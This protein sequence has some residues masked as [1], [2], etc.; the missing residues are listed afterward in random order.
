MPPRLP[1]SLLNPAPGP[2]NGRATRTADLTAP[3]HPVSRRGWLGSTAGAAAGWLTGCGKALPA[4]SLAV[5]AHAGP[6]AAQAGDTQV[7][8]FLQRRPLPPRYRTE[9]VHL[10]PRVRHQIQ[11]FAEIPTSDSMESMTYDV[12]LKTL[13]SGTLCGLRC[14]HKL[15]F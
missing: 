2:T 15:D 1:S 14:W 3:A 5:Q 8:A 13:C 6:A 4:A 10:F 9:Q 7:Q 11:N 12:I